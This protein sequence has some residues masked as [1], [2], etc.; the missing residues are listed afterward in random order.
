MDKIDNVNKLIQYIQNSFAVE[1]TSKQL[2]AAILPVKFFARWTCYSDYCFSDIN[3]PNDVVSFVLLPYVSEQE[4][5]DFQ[6]FVQTKQPKDLKEVKNVDSDFLAYIKKDGVISIVFILDDFT[7]WLGKD[8]QSR[9]DGIKDCLMVFK[10]Q[11]EM[12]RDNA[13]NEDM[14]EYHNGLVKQ[15]DEICS[16]SIKK[17]EVTT[18]IEL[19]LV[20]ILGAVSISEVAKRLDKIEILGWFS[21]RDGILDK[22]QGLICNLFHCILHC[23]L[24][25]TQFEFATYNQD[26]SHKPFF[27]DF[28][29][30]SDILTGVIADYDTKSNGVSKDKFGKVL[31]E[32]FADNNNVLIQ[33]LAFGDDIKVSEIKISMNPFE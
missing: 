25:G 14:K 31:R 15:I 26:S 11:F 23:L 21:D 13:P 28:N 19:L 17:R 5:Q 9:K 6:N 8:I 1:N 7:N 29:R 12:W 2:D 4:Y 3:K 27:D 20:S 10:Q 22:Q 24:N 33:R 30:L 18:Y 32:Y 16:K